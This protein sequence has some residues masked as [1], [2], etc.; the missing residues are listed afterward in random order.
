MASKSRS[1]GT[2]RA[3]RRSTRRGSRASLFVSLSVSR[4]VWGSGSV[5]IQF[6]T[7][8]QND[9][10]TSAL[11]RAHGTMRTARQCAPQGTSHIGRLSSSTVA[12]PL[13]SP[14]GLPRQLACTK[15]GYAW[16]RHVSS[17]RG[18][19]WIAS[20]SVR[21][22]RSI[23]ET[24][25]VGASLGRC[26]GTLFAIIMGGR[27]RLAMRRAMPAARATQTS[28][29]P[30]FVEVHGTSGWMPAPGSTWP[31]DGV[32]YS[33]I[34]SLRAPPFGIG[35]TRWMR[36]AR[37]PPKVQWESEYGVWVQGCGCGCGWRSTAWHTS[38]AY[39]CQTCAPPR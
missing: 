35:K 17:A 36:P 4:G 6:R 23:R 8:L 39:P 5:S 16:A 2:A 30:P 28:L 29:V 27:A 9:I 20:C 24:A 37:M 31:W 3:T 14:C 22:T 25:R 11:A 34:V 32:R 26:A 18:G 38:C 33:P 15:D 1:K 7:P 13:Q 10:F 19:W 12:A 21:Y